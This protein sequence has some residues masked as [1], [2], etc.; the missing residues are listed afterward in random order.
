MGVIKEDV[1]EKKKERHDKGT[2]I[3]PSELVPDRHNATKGS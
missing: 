3:A 2:E 1:H